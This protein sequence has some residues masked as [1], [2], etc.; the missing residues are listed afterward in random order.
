VRGELPEI[1]VDRNRLVQVIQNLLDNSAKFMGSQ[2]HPQI[3]IGMYANSGRD[4]FY[5][6]DNGVGIKPEFHEKVFGVFDKLNPGTDGTGDGL[7]L[8]KRIVE[9]HGGKIWIESDGT[10]SG[11]TICF[12]LG[13]IAAQP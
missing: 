12:T 7:A 13:E 2:E 9:V 3:E 6:K 8:V 10:G 5:V 1:H 11:T 4:V